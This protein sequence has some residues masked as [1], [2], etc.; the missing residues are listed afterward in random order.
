[1]KPLQ[2]LDVTKLT[3]HERVQ[4]CRDGYDVMHSGYLT[5]KQASEDIT[6]QLLAKNWP[7]NDARSV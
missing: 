4:L 2:V 3:I 5:L 1:M 6:V 7:L